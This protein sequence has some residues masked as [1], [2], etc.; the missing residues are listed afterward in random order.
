MQ[1]ILDDAMARVCGKGV[2]RAA[3]SDPCLRERCLIDDEWHVIMG[4]TNEV[5]RNNN[6]KPLPDTGIGE[7]QDK[8]ENISKGESDTGSGV[9]VPSILSGEAGDNLACRV[10]DAACNDAMHL[11]GDECDGEC[12]IMQAEYGLVLS[13]AKKVDTTPPPRKFPPRTSGLAGLPPI[14][15][16]AEVFLETSD[17]LEDAVEFARYLAGRKKQD[18]AEQGAEN[19]V[20]TDARTAEAHGEEVEVQC[21]IDQPHKRRKGIGR[22]IHGLSRRAWGEYTTRIPALVWTWWARKHPPKN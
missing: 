13:S 6:S 19:T 7:G 4:E 3:I 1:E 10:E 17:P 11:R 16:S 8:E 21:H 5:V 14:E 2:E 22:V 15:E 18:K 12:D 20:I 9:D